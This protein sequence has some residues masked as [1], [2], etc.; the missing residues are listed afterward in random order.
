MIS[1]VRDL[2]PALMGPIAVACYL[3][4]LLAF[5]YPQCLRRSGARLRVLHEAR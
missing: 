3:L 1:L 2:D 5:V 4:G